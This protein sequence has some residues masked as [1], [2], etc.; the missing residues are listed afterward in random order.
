MNVEIRSHLSGG[1]LSAWHE[2]IKNAGLTA[3]RCAERTVLVFEGDELIAT[4]ARDGYVLKYLAVSERHRGE[5]LTSVVLSELRRDAFSDGYRHLFLY[6][7][8]ENRYTLESLFFYPVVKSADVLVMENKRGGLSD[9]LES[10]PEAP[11]GGVV[12]ATVMNCNPFTLG[13]KHLI[14][15]AA[16]E[17]KHMFVFVLSEDKS[18]FSAADRLEMVRRGTRHLKNVTVLE[19][20][21]Y[22]ISSS[23]FP[24]Y[25]LKDRERAESAA[26][27][28]D[29]EMFAQHLA[30]RLNITRR[31]VGTEPASPL[32]AKYNGALKK[33][34]PPRGVE[35]H[36]VERYSE[37]G[38]PISASAV[39]ELIRQGDL[40]GVS[41]LVPKTTLAYLVEKNYLKE[42]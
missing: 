10:L 18:D 17:C 8:P 29:I 14:E 15:R 27:E 33:M 37:D 31:Y 20:G 22:L 11:K 19:T 39:R 21:P 9:Y 25:F 16:G 12:G 24:T 2:L 32:T 28:V 5:D 41:R 42:D 34:L 13:H 26:C 4:G 6:T 23:T 30:P 36:E 35:V 38:A 40:A 1:T 7:K 3:E